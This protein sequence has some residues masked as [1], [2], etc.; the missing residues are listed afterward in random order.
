MK[1]LGEKNLNVW[2][3]IPF[4]SFGELTQLA[5]SPYSKIFSKNYFE[6]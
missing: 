3:K 2:L 1:R 6:T 5:K 4:T